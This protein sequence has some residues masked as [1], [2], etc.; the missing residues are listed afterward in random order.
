MFKGSIVALVTPMDEQGGIDYGALQNLVRFHLEEGTDGFLVAGTTGESAVLTIEEFNGLIA[1]VCEH[2]DGAVPVVAGTGSADTAKT[3]KMTRLAG[4][5]GADAALVVTPYYNRPMQSGLAAHFTAVADATE[6]PLIMYNVPA[7]TSVDML[8]ETSATLSRQEMIVGIKEARPD[9]QRVARLVEAC[10]A[11]FCVMSGDDGSCKEAMYRGAQGVI[12][13]AANVQ[14][15]RMQHMCEAAR[16]GDHGQA[17][18]LDAEL[19]ELFRLLT[20][21]SNPIPVKWAVQ[22][23]GLIANGIRLPLL[24]LEAR[25]HA[26]VRECLQKLQAK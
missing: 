20:I 18:L 4:R 13:V 6:I 22:E 2:V 10:P 24:P 21:E 9:M 25:H 8:A 19:Q 7:R 15:A 23:M 5:L 26:A 3:I 17:D 11:D 1:A 14:P 12:S 16:S